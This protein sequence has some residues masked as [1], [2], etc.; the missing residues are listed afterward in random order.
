MLF[1]FI[2][3]NYSRKEIHHMQRKPAL[4]V[5]PLPYEMCPL[6]GKITSGFALGFFRANHKKCLLIAP[7]QCA[8]F[9]GGAE[10]KG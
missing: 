9:W 4:P 5:P 2:L 1:L 3:S 7:F 10:G 8:F 6:L